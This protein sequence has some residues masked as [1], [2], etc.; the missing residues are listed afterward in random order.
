MTSKKIQQMAINLVRLL[1]LQPV[2]AV[3]EHMA[4]QMRNQPGHLLEGVGLQCTDRIVVAE[5]EQRRLLDMLT[6]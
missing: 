3:A 1:A 2:T 5:Q 4:L 6:G